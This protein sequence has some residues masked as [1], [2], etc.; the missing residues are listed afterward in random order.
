[1]LKSHFIRRQDQQTSISLKLDVFD[2]EKHG[3]E[4]EIVGGEDFVLSRPG[5]HR[6]QHVVQVKSE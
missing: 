4:D 2:E 6:H 1:G 5:P 3:Q